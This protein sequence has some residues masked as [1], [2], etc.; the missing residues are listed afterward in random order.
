MIFVDTIR[1]Y[2]TPLTL[3][4]VIFGP[5]LLNK[6]LAYL[7]RRNI[8]QSRQITVVPLSR[9]LKVFLTL[10]T[11]YHLSHLFIPPFDL[12]STP[13]IPILAPNDVL[14]SRLYQGQ[15]STNALTDLLLSRLQNL[16]NRFMYLRFGHLVIQDCL[17]CM[18]P[19]DYLVASLPDVLSRYV[20]AAG[21]IMA[22]GSEGLVG[23]GAERRHRRW[24]GA[25]LWVLGIMCIAELGI[26]YL[27]DLRISGGDCLHVR[28]FCAFSADWIAGPR[29]PPRKD[30]RA[31]CVAPS[32][33]LP[34]SCTSHPKSLDTAQR[35]SKL[36]K[37][38]APHLSSSRVHTTRDPSQP[39]IIRRRATASLA[40][41]GYTIRSR[42]QTGDTGL[43]SRR[44][45]HLASSEL[46]RGR[47]EW[48]GTSTGRTAGYMITRQI[49]FYGHAHLHKQL[50]PPSAFIR[51]MKLVIRLRSIDGPS[52][53]IYQVRLENIGGLTA[54]WI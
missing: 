21:V 15:E 46:G 3:V 50:Y 53:W 54:T 10:H 33:L 5:Q 40:D 32:S 20:L 17:W 9:R 16:D 18:T 22:L 14:R 12:F 13:H 30:G 1:A 38:T 11:L 7:S 4:L 52:D 35:P 27:W 26:K 42:G 45:C 49:V 29:D 28:P 37:H 47:M 8:P 24:G 25:G 51:D 36:A 31:A 44:S 39:A 34:P 2:S 19:L 41:S 6:S 48:V 43:P 23:K